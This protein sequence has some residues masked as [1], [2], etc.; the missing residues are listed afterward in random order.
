MSEV[1]IKE[2]KTSI[3]A[4]F[5][6]N[7]LAILDLRDKSIRE[8][9]C[10]LYPS[11]PN[12]LYQFSRLQTIPPWAVVQQIAHVLNVSYEELFTSAFEKQRVNNLKLYMVY[13]PSKGYLTDERWADLDEQLQPITL[14]KK[15]Y[16]TRTL[17]KARAYT[18][19][20]LHRNYEEL[21]RYS[22]PA[23]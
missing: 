21:I 9:S 2:Y 18:M 23:N 22:L 11:Q 10:I 15:Q 16:F 14:E 3:G 19:E 4:V 17:N 7:L 8:L 6:N 12:K 5:W 13:V 1:A 20:E